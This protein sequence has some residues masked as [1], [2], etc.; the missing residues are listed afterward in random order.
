M[1]GRGRAGYAFSL[2]MD[3]FFSNGPAV[4]FCAGQTHL[5]TSEN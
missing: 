3:W 4:F 1:G 2:A 5:T